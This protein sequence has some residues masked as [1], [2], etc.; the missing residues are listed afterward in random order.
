MEYRVDILKNSL[1][2]I[3]F[4]IILN[5]PVNSCKKCNLCE[6]IDT[7]M[8]NE[9]WFKYLCYQLIKN[10][11]ISEYM[12]RNIHMDKRKSRCN[13]LMYWTYDKV[14]TFYEISSVK[15]NE[16]IVDVLI[17]VWKKFNGTELNNQSS[18]QCKAPEASEFR[19]IKKMKKKKIMS[20]YCENYH[21]HRRISKY[22]DFNNCQIYYDYFKDSL[23]KYKKETMNGCNPEDFIING[24]SEFCSNPDP[25]NVLN[26]SK[27]KTIEILPGKN[28]YITQEACD[29][30]KSEALSALKS[31][32]LTAEKCESKEVRI[33][34]FTFSDNRAII[35]ILFSMWGM[36]LTFVFLYKLMP[37]R[38]WISNK[39]GKKKIMRDSFNER[40]DNELLDADYE[41]VGTDMENT[42][43][44]II[45]NTDW[46]SSR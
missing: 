29:E 44:N 5:N 45:Y 20:D 18:P 7:N 42:G 43:Y 9:H 28:D 4:D 31:E 37:F 25:D 41:S 21:E 24:C 12:N 38:T 32:A 1:Q 34:E 35:L 39:L 6:Q 11:E 33:P 16:K 17:D 10:L 3:Q 27:C 15:N 22:V 23:S 46:N 8:K 40:S 26:N 30:L 2:P 13:S 14:K 19:N 36:F